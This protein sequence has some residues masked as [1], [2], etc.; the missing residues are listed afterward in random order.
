MFWE[1]EEEVVYDGGL[2]SSSWSDETHGDFTFQ[3]LLEEVPLA[4]CVHC[5]DY[6]FRNLHENRRL[7][8]IGAKLLIAI[9]ALFWTVMDLFTGASSR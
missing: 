6:D 9:C 7:I 2:P 1:G 4:D 8:N 3:H 5:F